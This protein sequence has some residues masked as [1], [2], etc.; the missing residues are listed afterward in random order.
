MRVKPAKMT[1]GLNFSCNIYDYI[2]YS[3]DDRFIIQRTMLKLDELVKE[4]FRK[5]PNKLLNRC[6]SCHNSLYYEIF[7]KN[8]SYYYK[9]LH[10]HCHY[11]MNI[12]DWFDSLGATELSDESTQFQLSNKFEEEKNEEIEEKVAK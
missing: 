12:W 7:Y 2:R 1:D 6:P 4:T 8:E 10:S 11:I 3:I 9:C 5:E